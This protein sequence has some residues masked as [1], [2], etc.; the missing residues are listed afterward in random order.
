MYLPKVSRYLCNLVGS[1]HAKPLASIMYLPLFRLTNYISYRCS[2]TVKY[3]HLPNF[4]V[5]KHEFVHA[6]DPKL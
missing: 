1:K 2:S 5:K 4:G 6:V 3:E